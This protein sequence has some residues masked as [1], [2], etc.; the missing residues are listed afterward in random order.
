MPTVTRTQSSHK[1]MPIQSKMGGDRYG[2]IDQVTDHQHMWE[3]LR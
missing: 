1:I 2:L 3:I